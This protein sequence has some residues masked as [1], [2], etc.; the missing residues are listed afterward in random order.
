MTEADYLEIILKGYAD[1]AENLHKHFDR[2]CQEAEKKHIDDTEFFKRLLHAFNL[3]MQERDK[4]YDEELG[5]VNLMIQIF[6]ENEKAGISQ[7]CTLEALEQ[8]KPN[9]ED[10]WINLFHF[11]NGRYRGYLASNN[12]KYIVEAILK[13]QFSTQLRNKMKSEKSPKQKISTIKPKKKVE[14]LFE[15]WTKDENHYNEV[16][17]FLKESSPTIGSSFIQDITGKLQWQKFDNNISYLA[18]FTK[19]CIDKGHINDKY[20]APD[21]KRIFSNT[22]NIEF[23]AKPFQS[24]VT[25]NFNGYSDAFINMP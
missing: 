11:T 16:I 25:K 18:A 17:E 6:N 19:A 10:C 15:V 4:A 7:V 13:S 8:Q 3:L 5:K 22:F 21:Y 14:T 9:I 12:L 24:I 2:E 23:N 1:N 20:S